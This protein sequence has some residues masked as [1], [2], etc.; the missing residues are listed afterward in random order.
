[1]GAKTVAVNHTV[2]IGGDP[3]GDEHL[4]LP[5][6]DDM[7]LS[8]NTTGTEPVTWTLKVRAS[9]VSFVF[10][11]FRVVGYALGRTT[12]SVSWSILEAFCGST[13]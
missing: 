1:M 6:G 4:T 12:L 8:C 11:N 13:L 3:K 5:E 10:M 2:R 7:I 9:V